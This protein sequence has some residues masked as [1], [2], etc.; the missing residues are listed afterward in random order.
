M[1]KWE[2]ELNRYIENSHPDLLSAIMEE[3]QLTDKIEEQLK[4]ALDGFSL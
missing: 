2:N 1:A 3:K 4:S